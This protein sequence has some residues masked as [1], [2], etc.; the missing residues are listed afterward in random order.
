MP[1]FTLLNKTTMK[2]NEL[3]IGNLVLIN[4]DLLVETKDEIYK[5]S[6]F[7]AKID[8][9]FPDSCGTISLDHTKSLRT[10][11]QFDEF[12]EPIPLTEEWLIKFGF[13]LN[14]KSNFSIK[15]GHIENNMF[16]Y[17]FNIPED[18]SWLEYHGGAI[19]CKHVHQ[20]QNLYFYLTGEELKID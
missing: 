13:E 4:N 8:L 10:Y 11:N 19:E 6:G 2:A 3:R 1:G 17:K 5:V 12:I 16:S 15:Y 18:K 7:N 20:L 14:Y 9:L